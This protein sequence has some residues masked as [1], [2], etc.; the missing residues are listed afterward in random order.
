MPTSTVPIFRV[1]RVVYD[2]RRRND[3]DA[4]HDERRVFVTL[5][6]HARLRAQRGRSDRASPRHA[7]SGHAAMKVPPRAVTLDSNDRRRA[8]SSVFCLFGLGG[9]YHDGGC[10][11]RGWSA[12]LTSRRLRGAWA[13]TT[14]SG[15]PSERERKHEP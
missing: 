5:D 8:L 9:R 10:L 15:E 13:R 12:A 4:T 14:A 7:S 2:A 3:D 11:S 6:P 1:G